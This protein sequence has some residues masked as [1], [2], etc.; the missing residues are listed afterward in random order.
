MKKILWMVSLLIAMMGFC[1]ALAQEKPKEVLFTKGQI[2]EVGSDTV[3]VVGQGSHGEIVLDITASTHI[4]SAEDGKPV[5][6][7]ALEKGEKVVAYYGPQVRKSMPPQA[8]AIALVVGTPISGGVGM[9][10]HVASVQ[11]KSDGNIRA[12]STN[13]D[14]LITI[15]KELFPQYNNVREGS[16]LIV[17]YNMMTMSMPGQATAIKA[18][19]LPAQIKVYLGAGV[20]VANGKE[21]TLDEGDNILVSG[22]KVMLPLRVIMENLGYNLLWDGERQQVRVLTGPHIAAAFRI[23]STSYQKG[24]ELIELD[25]APVVINGKTLMPVEFFSDILN[26]KVQIINS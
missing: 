23:G 13:G 1:T 22:D 7:A 5:D 8:N 17:W 9:Y 11:K 26:M 20:I 24:Q 19:L 21:L 16:E 18:V 10:M 25:D 3:R 6:F 12:L 14:I 4:V 15:R 2:A